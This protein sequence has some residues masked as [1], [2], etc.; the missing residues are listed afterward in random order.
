M[1]NRPAPETDPIAAARNILRGM[2]RDA[3]EGRLLPEGGPAWQRLRAEAFRYFIGVPI[4][5]AC[6]ACLR[7]LAR[8]P[9]V[10]E[11]GQGCGERRS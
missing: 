7:L 4:L 2:A 5:R 9:A 6:R 8:R 3:Q 11:S 1:S 10:A